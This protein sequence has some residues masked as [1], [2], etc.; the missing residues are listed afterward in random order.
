MGHNRNKLQ[1]RLKYS[2]KVFKGSPKL[3]SSLKT[4]KDKTK[5]YFKLN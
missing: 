4:F 2:F 1:K 5:N 3:Y